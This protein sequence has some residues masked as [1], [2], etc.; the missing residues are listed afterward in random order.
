[1]K[2]GQLGENLAAKEY[3]RLGFRIIRRNVRFH[4]ARQIGE[5]D[6]VAVKDNVLVFVEVKTR[7]SYRYGTGAEAVTYWK[8]RR[9][10]R[11]AKI[12][13]NN[14]SIYKDWDWRIDVAEVDVDNSEKPVI[15]L[16][17]AIEDLD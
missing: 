10:V 12:F 4:A 11:S 9:L 5:I 7:K 8:Q 13:V 15:L 16:V 2:L 14:N 6:L 3:E 17:N 1:M